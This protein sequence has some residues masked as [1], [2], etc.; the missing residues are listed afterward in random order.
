MSLRLMPQPVSETSIRTT[1]HSS[2]GGGFAS[3]H[4]RGFE[5]LIR[6]LLR[7]PGR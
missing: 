4:R 3:P 2:G 5:R 1:I 6:K 7:L